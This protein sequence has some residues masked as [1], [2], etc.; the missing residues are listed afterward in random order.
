MERYNLC[1]RRVTRKGQKLSGHL[2]EIKNDTTVAIN[3]R[4]KEDGGTLSEVDPHFFLNMDQTAVYFVSKSSTVVAKKGAKSVCVR[5]SGSDAKRATIVVTV[6]ADGTKLDPFF[7]FKAGPGKKVEWSLP[8]LGIKGCCQEKGWFDQRVG[9]KWI[10][11][12][13]EPY[14]RESEVAFL[15]VVPLLPARALCQNQRQRRLLL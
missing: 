4:F 15:L 11:Q 7:V 14:V 2:E 10:E 13:L 12:V 8:R 6:A 9:E 5:D 3:N 1:L